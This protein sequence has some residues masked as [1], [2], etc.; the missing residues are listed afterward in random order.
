MTMSLQESHSS[1]SRST[2]YKT[3][4]NGLYRHQNVPNGPGYDKPS[5]KSPHSTP[6]MYN[7]RLQALD[8]KSASIIQLLLQHISSTHT[9]LEMGECSRS[10]KLLP[11]HVVELLYIVLHQT[12]KQTKPGNKSGRQPN[13]QTKSTKTLWHYSRPSARQRA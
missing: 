8:V 9:P 5:P 13:K 4:S 11:R 10:Q 3:D 1:S 2:L 6:P 7:R 12:N